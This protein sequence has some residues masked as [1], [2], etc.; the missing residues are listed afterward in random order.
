MSGAKLL[1]YH[2]YGDSSPRRGRGLKMGAD[3]VT[4]DILNVGACTVG[5]VFLG[6]AIAGVNGALIGI[7]VGLVLGIFIA[8]S[9]R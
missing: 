5:A 6:G 9:R 1:Y 4:I 8:R 3:R 2:G 7:A